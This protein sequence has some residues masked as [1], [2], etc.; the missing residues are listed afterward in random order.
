[1]KTDLSLPLFALLFC[2]QP[3]TAHGTSLNN[4]ASRPATDGLH[5]STHLYQKSADPVKAFRSEIATLI[6]HYQE[7]K[8]TYEKLQF[9]TLRTS[10]SEIEFTISKQ[11][12][13][14]IIDKKLILLNAIHWQLGELRR[15]SLH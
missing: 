11:S 10:L 6:T 5:L 15:Q 1:M 12:L 8:L 14:N 2:C 4:S 3:F 13:V 7:R 9:T